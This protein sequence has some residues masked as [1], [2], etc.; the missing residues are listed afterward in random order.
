MPVKFVSTHLLRTQDIFFL[1]LRPNI[2]MLSSGMS[3]KGEPR[4]S[5]TSVDEGGLLAT[6]NFAYFRGKDA[7]QL[8]V[9]S[10]IFR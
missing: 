6:A 10:F 2:P 3:G 9:G 7:P 1:R 4:R 5:L 8:A